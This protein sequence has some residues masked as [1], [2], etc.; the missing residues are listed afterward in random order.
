[1]KVA[2]FGTPEIAVPSLHALLASHHDVAC[3]VTRPDKPAGR[4]RTMRPPATVAAA[5][6]G[7]VEVL[8]PAKAGD[9]V[10]DLERRNL[11]V[12]VVVAYGGWLP[13]PVLGLAPHGCVNLHPS[14]LPRW[15]G[16]APIERAIMAG[17]PTTGVATMSI[18]EGLDTGPIYLVVETPIEPEDTAATLAA[19]LGRQGAD[20]VLAT[21]D[22]IERGS[23]SAV[24]QPREGVTYADKVR[25]E[26]CRIDWSASAAGVDALVRGANPRPGAW[27][28]AGGRR[29]KIWSTRRFAGGAPVAPPGTV[30]AETPLLVATGD[31]AVEVLEVQP[32]GKARM[33]AAA[34]VRGNRPAASTVVFV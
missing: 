2:F 11:D 31:G 27:T 14:L 23:L 12:V 13:P 32:D 10:A 33:D 6:A 22:G 15:R 7:G 17:D 21:L 24:A 20:L 19:R 26:D 30:I 4:D 29:L 28:E 34:Y 18:D 3:L 1:M 25:P 16:A 9:C 5:H 8:Q